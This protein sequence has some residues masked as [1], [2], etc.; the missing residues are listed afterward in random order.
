MAKMSI[1]YANMA[2]I[3]QDR[4]GDM[5]RL[6]H[7]TVDENSD[8]RTRMSIPHGRYIRLTHGSDV[9]M[10]D[11][12]MEKR[13]N[14]NFVVNAHG[15][16]L[17]AGLGIGMILLAI[18]DKPEVQKIVV[19]EK[20]QEVIDLVAD[21]LPLNDKVEIVV[22]DINEYVPIEKFNTIY[23]DIWNWI[24]SDVYDDEMKP[25]I[26][27]FRKYL[28]SKAEDPNRFIDCWAKNEAK[29]NRNLI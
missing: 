21:Q 14:L 2:E 28:V 15:K 3:L 11:T 9:V 5:F 4:E 20:Y 23:F 10:S 27:K 18:Q 6:S 22:G 16:V 7:F 29:N 1:V 24:H 8:F 26:S 19:V 13:T 12:L 17:V 25:L